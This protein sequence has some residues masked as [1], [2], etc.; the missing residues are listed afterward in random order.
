MAKLRSMNSPHFLWRI[1]SIWHMWSPPSL[2]V[3]SSLDLQS[4]VLLSFLYIDFTLSHDLDLSPELQTVYPTAHSMSPL[5]C[6]VSIQNQAPNSSPQ[7]LILPKMFFIPTNNSKFVVAKVQCFRITLNSSLVLLPY[8]W[9]LSNNCWLYLQHR[10]RI[11]LLPTTST[12]N[13][14]ETRTFPDHHHLLPGFSTSAS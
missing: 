14:L 13:S 7:Y 2:D 10:A 3:L 5:G 6:L 9:F 11:W 8:I 1:C 12:A 4:S